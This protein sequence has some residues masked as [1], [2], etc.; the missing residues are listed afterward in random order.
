MKDVPPTSAAA[1]LA[2]S[3]TDRETRDEWVRERKYTPYSVGTVYTNAVRDLRVSR[4]FSYGLYS[5]SATIS[6]P[7]TLTK[8]EEKVVGSALEA[9]DKHLSDERERAALARLIAPAQSPKSRKAGAK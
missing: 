8:A 4:H 3:L 5:C 2:K 1:L 9:F 6:T 7:F